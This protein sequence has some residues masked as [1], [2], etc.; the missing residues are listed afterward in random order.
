[1]VAPLPLRDGRYR[2]ASSLRSSSVARVTRATGARCP[3]RPSLI[4][5]GV[6]RR[7]YCCRLLC[8]L[9]RYREARSNFRGIPNVIRRL[10][11]Y[12]L[13]LLCSGGK[14]KICRWSI[15]EKMNIGTADSTTLN[16]IHVPTYTIYKCNIWVRKGHLFF[17]EG[18]YHPPSPSHGHPSGI[19]TGLARPKHDTIR[20]EEWRVCGRRR[21]IK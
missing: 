4:Y 19:I 21:R 8:G 11:Q 5:D 6:T 14:S 18:Y 2:G 15:E 7:Y 9:Q 10:A 3:V 17:S 12:L 1:M 13:H 16:H 20:Q